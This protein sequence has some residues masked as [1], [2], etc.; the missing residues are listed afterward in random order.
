[1]TVVAIKAARNPGLEHWCCLSK[2]AK[3]CE[4]ERLGPELAFHGLALHCTAQYIIMH[5]IV[6]EGFR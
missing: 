1:V 6:Q 2:E 4:S 3:A 5:F